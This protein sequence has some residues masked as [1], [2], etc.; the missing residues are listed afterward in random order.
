VLLDGA[1]WT[2]RSRNAPLTPGVRIRVVDLDGL[3]LIVEP[4]KEESS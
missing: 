1:W 2:V 3:E 4:N